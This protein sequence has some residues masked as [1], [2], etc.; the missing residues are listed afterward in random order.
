MYYLA[1]RATAR[2]SLPV[3]FCLL[4]FSVT[5]DVAATT[6]VLV[7]RLLLLFRHSMPTTPYLRP[8]ATTRRT[9]GLACLYDFLFLVNCDMNDFF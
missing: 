3:R 4:P 5:G 2:L 1:C 9:A 8:V 6:L 7:Y